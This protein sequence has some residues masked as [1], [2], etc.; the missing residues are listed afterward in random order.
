MKKLSPLFWFIALVAGSTAGCGHLDFTPQDDSN[1]V[2]NGTVAFNGPVTLPDDAVVLVRV[3]DAVP[4][5]AVT[6]APGD[7]TLKHPVPPPDMPPDVLG[8]KTI[9]NPGTP[10]IPFQVEYRAEADQLRHGLNI[11]AR[12]SYGGK[13]RYY[14]F[15]HYSLGSNDYTESHTIWVDAVQ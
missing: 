3:I 6:Q 8:E 1:R 14:N 11:E 12:V 4:P 5:P 2:L 9:R 13:V 10:P 15:D 7:T